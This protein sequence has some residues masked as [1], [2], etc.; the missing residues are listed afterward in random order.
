MSAD[1]Q[2]KTPT[3]DYSMDAKCPPVYRMKVRPNFS[4]VDIN[5]QFIIEEGWSHADRLRF[6]T[7]TKIKTDEDHP[8]AAILTNL[9]PHLLIR[10]YDREEDSFLTVRISQEGE[11]EI[12]CRFLP[13]FSLLL[14]RGN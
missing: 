11:I 8:L 12:L 4:P 3:R 13:R 10:R 1:K 7:E 6:H 14:H 9:E 5:I 2:T